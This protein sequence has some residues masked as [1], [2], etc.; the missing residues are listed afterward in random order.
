MFYYMMI[1]DTT[2]KYSGDIIPPPTDSYFPGHVFIV[3]KRWKATPGTDKLDDGMGVLKVSKKGVCNENGCYVFEIYQSYVNNYNITEFDNKTGISL[4]YEKMKRICKGL[5][6]FYRSTKWTDADVSFW[7]ELT[8][9]NVDKYKDYDVSGIRFCYKS[10]NHD[11]WDGKVSENIDLIKKDV[12][13]A[14]LVGDFNKY[15]IKDRNYNTDTKT[16]DIYEI[17]DALAYK[18]ERRL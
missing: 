17:R 3:S 1:T 11:N 9:V 7:K 4:S 14:I 8:T 2:M 15:D 6:T 12:D 18:G 5:R 13:Q 16:H 10:F